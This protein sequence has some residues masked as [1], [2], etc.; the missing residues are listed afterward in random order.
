VLKP[1]QF[2]A[3]LYGAH[4]ATF[5]VPKGVPLPTGN[6]GHSA[7]LDFNTMNCGGP[8]CR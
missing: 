5:F 6:A 1:M 2:P 3:G 7:V 8:L 4:S